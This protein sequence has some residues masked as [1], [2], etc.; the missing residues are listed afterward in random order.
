M[1]IVATTALDVF[2]RAEEGVVS[3]FLAE[4]A[5][6][7]DASKRQALLQVVDEV[8]KLPEAMRPQVEVWAGDASNEK[9]AELAQRLLVRH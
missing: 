3:E 4:Q 7:A 2:D 8:G 9:V 6:D 1:R 5:V